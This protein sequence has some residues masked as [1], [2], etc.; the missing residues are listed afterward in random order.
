MIIVCP[1]IKEVI[2]KTA[3]L[4]LQLQNKTNKRYYI[5]DYDIRLWRYK[6]RNYRYIVD[7]YLIVFE[8]IGS[9]SFIKIK[10]VLETGRVFY[11]SFS[12]LSGSFFK[13]TIPYIL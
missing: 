1:N 10:A 2:V 12:E 5:L 4:Q 7:P 9:S 6:Q 3:L 11:N 8:A 13:I